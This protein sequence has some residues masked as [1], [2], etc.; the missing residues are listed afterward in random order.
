MAGKQRVLA[1]DPGIANLGWAFKNGRK[2]AHGV[3]KTKP[4]TPVWGRIEYI[5]E[6]STSLIEKYDPVTMVVE[7]F[8]NYMNKKGVGAVTKI[9][10]ILTSLGW[11]YG[12]DVIV[13]QPDEWLKD[14]ELNGKDHKEKTLA[15]AEELGYNVKSQHAAD[16]VIM[17]EWAKR[18]R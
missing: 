1:F 10:G 13:T 17:C 18:F 3:I 15:L 9:V 4:S 5:Y 11:G 2:D 12:L 8:N 14:M 16:A 7:D 6:E